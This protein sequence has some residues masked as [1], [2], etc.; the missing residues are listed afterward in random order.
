MTTARE[1]LFEEIKA[2][3]GAGGTSAEAINES[4]VALLQRY[5]VQTK[6]RT[7]I[8]AG[9]T[10]RDALADRLLAMWRQGVIVDDTQLNLTLDAFRMLHKKSGG[11]SKTSARKSEAERGCWTRS[12]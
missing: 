8:P 6:P 9:V 3:C 10:A 12:T 11:A 4:I 2:M 7:Q 1:A 5:R